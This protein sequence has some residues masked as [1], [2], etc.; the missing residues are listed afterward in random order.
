MNES[1]Q[2]RK[3]H[4]DEVPVAN[5]LVRGLIETQFPQ[6]SG[7]AI[8]RIRSTGTDNVIYRLG[9]QMGVRLPRIHWAVSQ[10]DKEWVWLRRLA[11]ELPVPVPIPIA[12]GE[13]G[14]GCPYPWLVYPWIEGEDLQHANGLDL[15]RTASDVAAFV[16]AL[17]RAD[18][19]D[20]P[21]LGAGRAHWHCSTGKLVGPSDAWRGSTSSVSCRYGTP[22]C[23][24]KSG[25]TSG[26]DPR[27]SPCSEPDHERRQPR[28]CD[29]LERY[30]HR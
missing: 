19:G 8:R 23:V 25:E 16:V 21:P 2:R 12:K 7:L 6:W 29:R 22:P 26:V 17:Q 30:R 20:E 13:P 1:R 27:G 10:V 24:S 28:W 4:D 11:P 14:L 5:S 18:P 15:H 9:D 3:M